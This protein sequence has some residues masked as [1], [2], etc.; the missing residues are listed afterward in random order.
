RHAP[1]PPPTPP[2]TPGARAQD[3]EGARVVTRDLPAAELG[4]LGVLLRR[5]AAERD[6][7]RQGQRARASA[8]VDKDW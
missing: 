1:T 5:K 4:Q 7:A 6:A 2:P 3:D 8:G